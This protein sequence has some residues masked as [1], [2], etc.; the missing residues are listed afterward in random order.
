[1]RRIF[2]LSVRPSVCLSVSY[3]YIIYLFSE[4]LGQ[5]MQ[6]VLL[7]Y[8]RVILTEWEEQYQDRAA[9]VMTCISDKTKIRDM[10]FTLVQSRVSY[11]L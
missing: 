4:E 1:M 7:T 6:L 8:L 9:A 5:D 2:F 10:F 3:A 11:H